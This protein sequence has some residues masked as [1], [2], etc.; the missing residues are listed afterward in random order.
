MLG[1]IQGITEWLPIS[2]S[3]WA[4]IFMMEVLDTPA[5]VA[6][7]MVA[8]LHFGTLIA[9]VVRFKDDIQKMLVERGVLFH[10]L[11]RSTIVTGVVGVPV[12]LI[13]RDVFGKWQ[14]DFVTG[15]IGILLVLMGIAL[16]FGSGSLGNRRI[17]DIDRTDEIVS[18]AAQG[19]SLLPGI[20]RSG[21]TL[22]ALLLRGFHQEDALKISFLM[23]IPV[24]AGAVLGTLALDL[25]GGEVIPIEPKYIAVGVLTAFIS[26]YLTIDTFLKFARGA[27]FDMFCIVLGLM[28]ILF[29]GVVKEYENELFVILAI[30]LLWVIGTRA[31]MI[32]RPHER[33]TIERFGRYIKTIYPGLGLIIPFV[34][35]CR[36]VDMRERTLE[37]PTKYMI[38][39]DNVGVTI[40]GIIYFEVVDECKVLYNVTRFDLAVI[41]IVQSSLRNL[42]G[43]MVLDELIS[44]RD[45]INRELKQILDEASE[46]WG[47]HITRIEIYRIVPPADVVE[48]MS[49]QMKSE[50]TKRARIFEAEGIK[51]ATILT[52]E[53]EKKGH[54][55]RAEGKAYCI[56]V[57]AKAERYREIV[58][59]EGEAT[60]IR[61]V[62][63]A[64]HKGNPTKFLLSYEYLGALRKVADGRST[65][66]FL[67]L[68]FT[69]IAGGIS[70]K[71]T[72]G[73]VNEG[74]KKI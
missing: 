27:N 37:I 47:V 40:D 63:G 51:L 15:G 74:R 53:G 44:S 49:H 46:N 62:F 20:S 6:F 12:Y 16:Y 68:D 22:V 17:E 1:L 69:R 65:K 57:K 70:K 8:Y 64:I 42:V 14:G 4:M 35:T 32:I 3:G 30:L 9:V 38:T 59:A 7:R 18:G 60:A 73:G 52:A 43:N 5:D 54:I 13:L 66:L 67:P 24:V 10:F 2:S 50:R 34:D 21:S 61:D 45:R 23:S 31:V 56:T 39:K 25:I 29:S 33:G 48:A 36:F 41:H 71:S 26:G 58:V 11:I 19:L 28:T 72:N 55:L